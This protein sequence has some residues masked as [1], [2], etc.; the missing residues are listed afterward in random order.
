RLR[1]ERRGLDDRVVVLPEIAE[2]GAA[3]VVQA[4]HDGPGSSGKEARARHSARAFTYPS[5][6]APTKGKGRPAGGAERPSLCDARRAGPRRV[7]FWVGGEPGRERRTR[8]RALLLLAALGTADEKLLLD[9]GG[10]AAHRVLDLLGEVG[11][12][13]QELADVV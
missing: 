12:V 10:V 8:A 3:D 7:R 9:D 5:R 11:V 2:E 13:P 6:A 4:L 1:H